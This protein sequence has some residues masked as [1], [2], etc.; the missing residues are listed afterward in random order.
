[1]Y[2]EVV[3]ARQDWVANISWRRFPSF[4]RKN[5]HLSNKYDQYYEHLLFLTKHFIMSA[6]KKG[7]NASFIPLLRCFLGKTKCTSTQTNSQV[8]LWLIWMNCLLM[9][10]INCFVWPIYMEF[11]TLWDDRRRSRI[12]CCLLARVCIPE[13]WHMC[14]FMEIK[15]ASPE[16]CSD[17][18]H[19]HNFSQ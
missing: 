11:N 13:V 6:K 14:V 3:M 15:R 17:M 7:L 18:I 10:K 19:C 4:Q 2:R 9:F 8:P 16:N 1:M 12:C 5:N